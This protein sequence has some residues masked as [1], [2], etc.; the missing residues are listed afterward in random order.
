MNER[1]YQKKIYRLDFFG[2][3]SKNFTITNIQ[4]LRILLTVSDQ[5][6]S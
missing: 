5:R 4:I 6:G 2:E 1:M 3:F